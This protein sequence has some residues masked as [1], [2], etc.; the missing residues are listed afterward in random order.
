MRQL[1]FKRPDVASFV[2]ITTLAMLLLAT[3]G[4][5][6]AGITVK[7]SGVCATPT[8][9]VS[10]DGNA[11]VVRYE[12][13]EILEIC[14]N[15]GA[16]TDTVYYA[17]P[18]FG[19]CYDEGMPKL[20]MR[21][22]TFRVPDGYNVSIS[23]ISVNDSTVNC[24]YAGVREPVMDNS[25][26]YRSGY[27][28]TPY[29]GLYPASLAS[30]SDSY[31]LRGEDIVEIAVNPVRYD[32]ENKT[33]TICGE[34]EYRLSFTPHIPLAYD[35]TITPEESDE[36]NALSGFL[37][38][39]LVTNINDIG[40]SGASVIDNFAQIEYVIVTTDKYLESIKGF[41]QWKNILG[42]V[43]DVISKESWRDG[44][45]VM[46]ALRNYRITNR[47]V[48]YLLIVG[49]HED[50]PAVLCPEPLTNIHYSDLYYANKTNG[51]FIPD[52][53]AGRV[54]VN[55]AEEARETLDKIIH[56]EM[57]PSVESQCYDNAV[58]CAFFQTS[59]N[60]SGSNYQKELRRFVR[61][62]EEIRNYVAQFGINAHR[63]YKTEFNS[64]PTFYTDGTQIP[65]DL[66]YPAFRWSCTGSQISDRI[67][68]GSLYAL[69][70]GHGSTAGWS[71]VGFTNDCLSE[72]SNSER[73]PI[74]FSI[75]CHT[76]KFDEDCFAE[77]LLKLP[78]AGASA[79]IAAS[80]MS[81]SDYNDAFAEGMID[82]IWPSPGLTNVIDNNFTG[83]VSATPTPTYRLGQIMHQGLF[84]MK[85][86]CVSSS[87]W[88]RYQYEIY[89]LFGDP[90]MYFFTQT[91][92]GFSNVNIERTSGEVTASVD[93]NNATISF[94][95]QTN[96]RFRRTQG[97]YASFS[98]T[99]PEKTIV[100]I[101]GH[102]RLPYLDGISTSADDDSPLSPSILNYSSE[103][104][105]TASIKVFAG[106]TSGNVEISV[107]DM[108]G[109][110]YRNVAVD[111]RMSIQDIDIELPQVRGVYVI[112]LKR[113]GTVVDTKKIIL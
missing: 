41:L 15:P 37:T 52:I 89:H 112:C 67:N 84:R 97:N 85:E 19:F 29:S 26:L 66:K 77:R 73:L 72:L 100:C 9:D 78:D 16:S 24:E 22:D 105:G 17:L 98:T 70:R 1:F 36:N 25:S 48:K 71:N 42:Y 34:I 61:T 11:I 106:E 10:I 40:E 91:P 79:V 39:S 83:D 2:R 95:D 59:E 57:C 81:I 62:S 20:P 31:E 5:S 47:N 23:S 58:H 65:E 55:T 107:C 46:S 54:S 110:Q 18:G 109:L 90:S 82:A 44:Y 27:P 88:I 33:A 30:I 43:T 56:A 4:L 50:V 60:G 113:N 111:G 99:M 51:T 80:Q 68:S 28:I 108:N 49:D 92:V 6:Y 86:Q 21:I 13:P 7:T 38:N 69:Y 103:G 76:G 93:D 87:S 35:E 45:D 74:V 96:G 53:Y 8:R 94:Y 101:S 64:F 3:Y 63:F 14:A 12:F 102:N 32:Y 104:N 75:T